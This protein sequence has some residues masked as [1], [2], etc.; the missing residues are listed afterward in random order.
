MMGANIKTL[1]AQQDRFDGSG[2]KGD[3]GDK[4]RGKGTK[5]K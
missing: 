3:G 4:L 1:W 5:C 2:G